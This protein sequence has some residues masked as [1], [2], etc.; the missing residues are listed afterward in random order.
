MNETR[1]L[2][3]VIAMFFVVS[4]FSQ[5]HL[6]TQ[7]IAII[8]GE[9]WWGG[10]VSDGISMPFKTGFSYDMYGNNKGNQVQPLLISNRG[11]VIWSEEPF[12]FTFK[13][14]EIQIVSH[15]AIQLD[16]AGNTLKE[17]YGFASGKYFPAS[18]ELPDELLFSAPQYNTWIE[19]VYDQN[20]E[21]ILEYARGIIRHGFPPGVLMIDD[22]WQEDYGKWNFH[23]GRF[24]NPREMIRELHDLGFKV[25]LWVCP[26]VSPDSDIYRELAQKGYFLMNGNEVK[27]YG[28]P[29]IEQ[30]QPA[31]IHWWN[32]VSAL[33]DLSHPGTQ[34]WFKGE[35]K[36]LVD[37]FDID[38]FKLDAGDSYFYPDDLVSY[39]KGLTPNDHTALFGQIGLDFPLNE[40]RAMWKMA[41]LP[42]AQRLSDKGHNWSDLSLLIPNIT[43]QGLL[44]YNFTCPDMI[45]GGE[46]N[47]FRNTATIDQ[48]LIVRSA[49]THA[50]MPMMQFSVAP[51]RILDNI[52]L[53]AV[54][55]SVELRQQFTSEIMDLV[56]TSAITG[57]PVV[58][59]MEYVFPNQGFVDTKDQFML[60]NDLLVAPVLIKGARS[61]WV[62]LPKGRWKAHTGKVYEGDTKI[63]IEAPLEIL[64]YFRKM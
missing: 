10:A 15:R 58:R 3:V 30:G 54:K 50:L 41:G 29:W 40:Y 31:M 55:K 23:P 61:K 13:N 17:A 32:G 48:E 62:S 22:N 39:E 4:C 7:K 14:D 47:S 8:Q 12:K 45:G 19:L 49:Q 52:H 26:F 60:G 36:H 44:G 51:W 64:P 16:S 5:N 18:G 53:Q 35:L 37:D 2:I 9:Y 11:R 6:E 59:T 24:P 42:L 56:K 63:E 43:T 33:L 20:Q 34:D 28:A 25:M 46:F 1:F 21:D 27:T 57:E 38:G